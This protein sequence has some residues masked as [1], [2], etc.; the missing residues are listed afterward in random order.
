MEKKAMPT[1]L[2]LRKKTYK[3]IGIILVTASAILAAGAMI[4]L[5]FATKALKSQVEQ[6][7]GP[8]SEIGELVVGWSAIEV[9]SVHLHAPKG[10]PASDTL[11]AER[12]IITPDLLGL[13]SARLH[14]SSITVEQAYLSVLRTRDGR[15]H[16]LP[17]LL[18][19]PTKPE[20]QAGGSTPAVTI[21]KIEL[22]D[23]VLEFFDASV[24]QPAHKL[25]LE[26]LQATVDELQVPSMAGHTQLQLSGKIKGVQRDG[27]L[28][29]KGWAELADKNS[30]IVTRLQGVD[31]V[32]LQ[33]YLIKASETGVR[34]GTL[35]LQ[36]QSS[37]HNNHLHAPGILT[38]TG[39]EL[40][41]GNGGMSTFMGVPRQMVL[42]ALKNR[43]DQIKIQF[44][45]E[46][47]LDD[48]HFSLNENFAKRI[49]ASVAESLG[50][51]IEGLA[52]GISSTAEG[53]G[54][55]VNKLFGN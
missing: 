24:R 5:H 4:G 3:R 49:S 46:G 36:L 35:D 52:Y 55:M 9:R 8:D 20:S 26:Q 21:G 34:R 50:I 14:V 10:W 39:L 13:L 38:L 41:S 29:I 31:L 27:K 43:N 28:D 2:A 11:R 12:I 22:R 25:R 37:V 54:G 51:N 18:E 47:N 19:Q 30:D 53:L 15:V 1:P 45:L 33:P 23:G 40:T 44:A 7:L 48:P 16:L 6:A 32:A 17:S 42:A